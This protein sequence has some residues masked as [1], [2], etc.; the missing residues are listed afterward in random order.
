M[1][2]FIN[3]SILIHKLI[4]LPF[5]FMVSH[6]NTCRTPPNC[7]SSKCLYYIN[8]ST[9]TRRTTT[10]SYTCSI[11][12]YYMR[13]FMSCKSIFDKSMVF[14]RIPPCFATALACLLLSL[15]NFIIMNI[16]MP[17]I[18]IHHIRLNILIVEINCA[19]IYMYIY[20]PKF[21]GMFYSIKRKLVQK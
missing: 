15:A 21:W 1:F 5:K 17:I 12:S 2:Y 11:L 18:T 7:N 16:I 20:N 19:N 14:L 3:H 4:E 13:M 6:K 10:N 8:V 9:S